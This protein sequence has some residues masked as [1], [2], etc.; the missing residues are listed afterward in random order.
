MLHCYFLNFLHPSN[1][2]FIYLLRIINIIFCLNIFTL[3]WLNLPSAESYDILWLS[4]QLSYFLG[5]AIINCLGF[6]FVCFHLD[7]CC[8]FAPLEASLSPLS[9]CTGLDL[10]QSCH[11]MT[12]LALS[13]GV[14]ASF[15][16]VEYSYFFHSWFALKNLLISQKFAE[17]KGVWEVTVEI[18][19]V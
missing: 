11:T 16:L 4:Q 19:C 13:W 14:P 2:P 12:S 1:P 15:F 8:F 3:F 18:F 6:F 17:K 5:K 9:S 7:F 10:F